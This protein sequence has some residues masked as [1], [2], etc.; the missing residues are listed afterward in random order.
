M[1]GAIAALLD[2][3]ADHVCFGATK[4]P[5]LA[6]FPTTEVF[7]MLEPGSTLAGGLRCSVN[8]LDLHSDSYCSPKVKRCRT[9]TK[10]S[11]IRSTPIFATLSDCV[12]SS[13]GRHRRLDRKAIPCQ[14]PLPVVRALAGVHVPL[15]IMGICTLSPSSHRHGDQESSHSR[16][17]HQTGRKTPRQVQSVRRETP[18][19]QTETRRQ[20]RQAGRKPDVKKAPTKTPVAKMET[21]AKETAK[22]P[23]KPASAK[24]GRAPSEKAPQGPADIQ[25]V[26]EI[27]PTGISPELVAPLP[28]ASRASTLPRSRR[29]SAN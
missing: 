5:T 18:A 6:G 25:P 19:D 7:P 29:R 10:R 27:K 3:G 1:I 15:A 8:I 4:L 23:R 14:L 11:P 20:G 24:P 26:D 28:M 21:A 22:A 17:L 13:A 12:D 16:A 2:V 9:N